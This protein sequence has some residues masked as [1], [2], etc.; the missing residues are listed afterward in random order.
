MQLREGEYKYFHQFFAKILD[1][2][3]TTYLILNSQKT[4]TTL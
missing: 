3:K 2:Q 4:T 1:T